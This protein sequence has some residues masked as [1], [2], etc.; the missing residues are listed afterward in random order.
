MPNKGSRPAAPPAALL[1]RVSS[2]GKAIGRPKT[3]FEPLRTVPTRCPAEVLKYLKGLSASQ[4][5]SLTTMFEDMLRRFLEDRPWDHGL[6]WRKP[7]VA[8]T[9]IGGSKG[10]TGWVQA[11]LQVPQDLADRVEQV[12]DLHGVS[13]A[14]LAYT[15]MF[16]WCQYI[17]PPRVTR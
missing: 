16:W 4:G 2:R 9:T 6:I 5:I 11:N 12:A 8:T 15:A 14:A 13:K 3:R 10:T 1:K 17:Y 7:K